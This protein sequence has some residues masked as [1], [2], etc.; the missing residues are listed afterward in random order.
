MT[1]DR[2]TCW[3]LLSLTLGSA[4]VAD[5]VAAPLAVV[6]G[7][8]LT[9]HD[10]DIQL[11]IME[12]RLASGDERAS[13]PAADQVLRR[14]IQNELFVQEG[15]RIGLQ[16]RAVIRNQVIEATRDR[17]SRALLDSV[18]ASAPADAP[19]P[20]EAR[21]LAVAD[22][23]DGLMDLNEVVVD[24]A[25][26]RSCDF[27]S[28]DDAAVAALGESEA[29]LATLPG[30][31]LEV[32]HLAREIR[33][34]EYHGLRGK[35]DAAERRDR[36]FREM[37]VTALVRRE[38]AARGYT[39]RAEIRR[40]AR[41]LERQLVLQEAIGVLL[42][43]DFEPTEAEVEAF[44]QAHL[45]E[46]MTDAQVKVDGVKFAEREPAE[47]FRERLL[48]G[49]KMGWLRKNTDD[50]ADGPP[51]FPP[52]FFDPREAG[53]DPEQCVVGAVL[54]LYEVPTGF[55][56]AVVEAVQEPTARPLA[57]CRSEVLQQMKSEQTRSHIDEIMARLEA[58]TPVE[59]LP[60]AEEAVAA[61]L[62]SLDADR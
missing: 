60:G 55:V 1:V 31:Q 39:E 19:D 54:D 42:T 48:A 35:P 47:R 56:V 6:A 37:L 44:W 7:D 29:V 14:L 10:L 21:R 26:L 58:A 20:S 57:E 15:Y 43:V 24:S 38:A 11:S 62:A 17:A 52:I 53:I 41:G 33:F 50:I 3:L 22:F 4:A 13:L 32:R 12:T 49:A 5:Q 36:I 25:L 18:A 16:D 34:R 40:R 59:I 45:D 2:V 27:A 51:P 23:I 8:T 30:A 46:Y 9:T 28:E 61:T